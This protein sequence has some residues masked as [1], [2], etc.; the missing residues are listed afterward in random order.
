M[1]TQKAKLSLKEIASRMTGFSIPVIGGGMSWKAPINE[2]DEVRAFL[3]A[4]EDRRV[5]YNPQQLEVE[6]QVQYS[7]SEIRKFCT[8]AISRLPDKSP[9][10]APIRGI[11]AACRHFLN[12]PKPDYRNLSTHDFGRDSQPGFF[13]ALGEFR[14]TVGAHVGVLA[15]MFEIELEPDLASI[16]PPSDK[17]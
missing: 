15:L 3:T 17:D 8:D 1:K 9:G 16:I 7:I 4:L 11:R 14:A 13:T 5:L 10:V 2:R 6:S 12:E